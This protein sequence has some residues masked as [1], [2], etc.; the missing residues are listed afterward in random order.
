[1]RAWGKTLPLLAFGL[2]LAGCG[3]DRPAYAPPAPAHAAGPQ[4]A[5]RTPLIATDAPPRSGD[6]LDG[7]GDPLLGENGGKPSTSDPLAGGDALAGP[8]MPTRHSHWLRGRLHAARMTVSLNGVRQPALPSVIDQDIT[9]RLRAGV[10]TV[11]F[12]Y[13]P[14]G[15]E[16]SATMEVVEGEHTPDIAPLVTFRP[17]SAADHGLSDR[18]SAPA[19]LTRTFTFVAK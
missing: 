7:G 1:M 8:Q 10:N 15:T 9:M 13:Q 14:E 6:P 2:P 18:A 12:D 16:S 4:S 3:S 17:A 19:P 11:T 5:A